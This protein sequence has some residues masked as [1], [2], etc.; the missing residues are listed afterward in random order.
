[1]ERILNNIQ[2]FPYT[3]NEFPVQENG[4]TN[5]LEELFH[6][7][8]Q[9]MY[10]CEKSF[11]AALPFIIINTSDSDLRNRFQCDLALSERRVSLAEKIFLLVG[12]PTEAEESQMMGDLLVQVKDRISEAERSYKTDQLIID[13]IQKIEQYEIAFYKAL[14]SF[15]K[16]L[17]HSEAAYLLQTMLL[18][19]EESNQA[20]T[21]LVE[22]F[23]GDVDSKEIAD[24]KETTVD[25]EQLSFQLGE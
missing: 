1:M 4:G 24:S 10:W 6:E 14:N 5:L 16:A 22:M 9:E 7:Q 20:L 21:W 15:A 25:I 17:E 11:S 12:K 8:L 3:A 2:Q 19:V 18:E 13:S 23:T